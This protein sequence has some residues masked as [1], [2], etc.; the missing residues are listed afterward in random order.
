MSPL[1][2][3][4]IFE[5]GTAELFLFSFLGSSRGPFS[6]TKNESKMLVCVAFDEKALE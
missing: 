1:P 6:H 2:L 5:R 3:S 4:L